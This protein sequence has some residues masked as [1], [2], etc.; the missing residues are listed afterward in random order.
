[1]NRA[2]PVERQIAFERV[3]EAVRKGNAG[4]RR[5]PAQAVWCIL[6]SSRIVQREIQE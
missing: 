3:P 5:F 4:T 1:L 6:L 2:L